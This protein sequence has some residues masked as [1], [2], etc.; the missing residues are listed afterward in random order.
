LINNTIAKNEASL[1]GGGIYNTLSYPKI[2]NTILSDNKAS[3]S[4]KYNQILD[5]YPRLLLRH[6]LVQGGWQGDTLNVYKN[7][8]L[9]ADAENND[10]R[11]TEFSPCVGRGIG[12]IEIGGVMYT[13]PPGDCEGNA[14]PCTSPADNLVD[15]GAYESNFSITNLPIVNP[16]VPKS[17]SLSQNYPNPFN[18]L[19]TINY[20]LPITNY[21]ELSIYNLLGQKVAM[22]VNKKQAA[23][24]HQVQW[25]G[26]NFASGVYYYRLT[27]GSFVET[28]KLVLLR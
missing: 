4:S 24:R 13:A 22:L 16:A 26:R 14:R 12:A 9:F 2:I 18:P 20:E 3:S 5:T 25:D 17:Y 7:D 28:K 23:G 10:F 11:L 1:S 15:I 6:S 21:V 27:A 19:T 8:P